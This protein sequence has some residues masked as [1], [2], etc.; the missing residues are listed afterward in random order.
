MAPTLHCIR[1]AQ[2]YHN[3]SDENE[4]KYHDP[5]LTPR[6]R[7]QCERLAK[8]FPYHQQIEYIIASPI[9]RT[10]QTALIGLDPAIKQHK[11]KLILAP[12]AQETSAK[13]SDT[14]TDLD[15][16]QEEYG[17]KLDARHMT[18]DWN[19]NKGEW[20][21]NSESIEAHVVELRRRISKL[22]HK[23]VA[24]V[25]HGGVSCFLFDWIKADS[26]ANTEYRSYDFIEG[27]GGHLKETEES[28][29]RRANGPAGGFDPSNGD[30][31]EL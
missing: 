12:R 9:R 15:K 10:I 16:L 24:L 8:D 18:D 2:G 5:D 13:P 31:D 1:H 30:A 26:W 11:L 19:T 14:G 21:M 23:H 28:R 25:A 6:G 4:E 3:L 7:E 17:E 22:P 29:K 27:N 20:Q